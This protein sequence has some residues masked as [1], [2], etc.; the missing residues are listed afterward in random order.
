MSQIFRM[1]VGGSGDRI[2][3]ILRRFAEFSVEKISMTD[4][5]QGKREFSATTGSD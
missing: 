2:H 1:V 3:S 5:T 4:A